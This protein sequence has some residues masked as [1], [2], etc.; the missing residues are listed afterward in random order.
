[1]LS[2]RVAST[3]NENELSHRWRARPLLR[4]GMLKACKSYLSERPAVGC[5]DW[6]G[7]GGANSM[8]VGGT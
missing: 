7:P 6:L 2:Y 1:M 5:S 4:S 3:P 8:R